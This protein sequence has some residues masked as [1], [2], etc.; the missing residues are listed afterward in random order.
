VKRLPFPGVRDTK[1][2][3]IGES[4]QIVQFTQLVFPETEME[5]T[6]TARVSAAAIRKAFHLR[7][8]LPRPERPHVH[9]AEAKQEDLVI[10]II[11]VQNT[12][13]Q[14]SSEGALRSSSARQVA[15]YTA[16]VRPL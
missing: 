10:T 15:G 1:A 12:A 13:F 14:D 6:V 3:L 16:W 7:L 4:K 11:V 5:L 2:H 9:H 8:A